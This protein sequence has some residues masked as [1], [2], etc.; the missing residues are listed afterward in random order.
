MS[1]NAL[2][3]AGITMYVY[4]CVCFHHQHFHTANTNTMTLLGVL[5]HHYHADN[6]HSNDYNQT[7][8]D[9]TATITNFSA[10][11]TPRRCLTHFSVAI[12][13][14]VLSSAN[15]IITTTSCF[16]SVV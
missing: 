11:R 2:N 10:P 9:V 14:C 4:A 5:V 8:R 12:H 1:I 16:R 15:N 7:L 6:H 13:P 3:S